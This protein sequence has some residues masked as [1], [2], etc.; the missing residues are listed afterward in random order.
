MKLGR[1]SIVYK[2]EVETLQFGW[3]KINILSDD[4]IT[5]AKHFSFGIVETKPGEG[6]DCHNHPDAEEI[7]FV[8]SGEAE[9]MIDHKPPVTVTAGA[10]IYL[11]PGVDHSTK[12][13]GTEPLLLIIAYGP[14]GAEKALR[15]IPDC[16]IL[17]PEKSGS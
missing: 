7:I 5:G 12:N 15:E 16:Q 13:I 8:L 11:P 9:Q 2:S 6:H 1:G 4:T 10:S 3:G 17:P 14:I